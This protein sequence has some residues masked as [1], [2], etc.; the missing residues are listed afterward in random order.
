[1][2]KKIPPGAADFR[3]APEP[4]PI[5]RSVERLGTKSRSRPNL[6]GAGVGSGSLTSE[7]GAANKSGGFATLLCS[8][9][10]L[11]VVTL[12]CHLKKEHR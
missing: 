5:L 1:M 4:E 2:S 11:A 12:R 3:A 8:R 7:D 6:A 10:E 9:Q